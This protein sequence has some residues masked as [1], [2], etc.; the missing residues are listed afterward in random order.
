MWPSKRVATPEINVKS[1]VGRRRNRNDIL[2]GSAAIC[3]VPLL[4][5]DLCDV[6]CLYLRVSWYYCVFDYCLFM[7]CLMLDVCCCCS[8]PLIWLLRLVIWVHR[9]W[10]LYRRCDYVCCCCYFCG[11]RCDCCCCYCWWWCCSVCFCLARKACIVKVRFQLFSCFVAII[12]GYFL[13]AQ[14][15]CCLPDVVCS[16]VSVVDVVAAAVVVAAVV[17]GVV[18]GV[19]VVVVCVVIVVLVVLVV[20]GVVVVVVVAV[21]LLSWWWLLSLLLSSNAQINSATHKSANHR[22][23]YLFTWLLDGRGFRH[24]YRRLWWPMPT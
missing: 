1:F 9:Q 14:W 6:G 18:V 19:D 10:L 21:L 12:L 17:L 15:W 22:Y 2:G 5:I 8:L 24:S 7:L 3:V 16:I 23:Y 11:C 13:S 4:R 20:F